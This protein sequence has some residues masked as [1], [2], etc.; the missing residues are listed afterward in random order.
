MGRY[1][2]TDQAE[3]NILINYAQKVLEKSD[4][5]IALG[6][7]R[8]VVQSSN[9]GIGILFIFFLLSLICSVQANYPHTQKW[10]P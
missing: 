8:S 10:V 4:S 3:G 5:R 2:T 1:A 7:I 6:F 9:Q